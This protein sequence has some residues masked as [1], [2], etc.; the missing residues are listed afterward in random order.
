[1]LAINHVTLSTACILGASI[2]FDREFFLPFILLPIFSTLLPDIDHPNSEI[3]KFFPGLNKF[4]PHRGIS[5]SLFATGLIAIFLYFLIGVE[6]TLINLSLLLFAFI[7]LFFLKKLLFKR[8]GSLQKASQGLLNRR[9]TKLAVETFAFI[10]NCFLLITGFIIWQNQYRFQVFSLL[11]LGY[12]GHL[13]GDLITKDGIPLFWPIK[14]RIALKLFRTGSRVEVFLGFL[15]F[16]LNIFLVIEFWEVFNLNDLT[17][18][19]KYIGIS[20]N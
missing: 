18:W 14:K 1:M 5:H 20:F 4:L 12:L 17:Y 10:L 9:Q 2:Y 3:S 7:G 8:I 15:L 11:V 6:D 19:E 13:V 16:V